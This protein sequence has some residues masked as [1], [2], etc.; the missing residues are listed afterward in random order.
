M[1][2][3]KGEKMV[4]RLEGCILGA[5][6]RLNNGLLAAQSNLYSW[7]EVDDQ[8]AA[9]LVIVD[10]EHGT[11]SAHS[12][13]HVV[14]GDGFQCDSEEE[15]TKHLF[16]ELE[17]M[18]MAVKD[19]G[20]LGEVKEV[21][22]VPPEYRERSASKGGEEEM[23]LEFG[24][25]EAKYERN[26][27]YPRNEGS[28]PAACA[29]FNQRFRASE[30][31]WVSWPRIGS[32]TGA[33]IEV[34]TRAQGLAGPTLG[35]QHTCAL[36]SGA[37]REASKG[38]LSRRVEPSDVLAAIEQAME[39]KAL[40][41]SLD[42]VLAIDLVDL[43]LTTLLWNLDTVGAVRERARKSRWGAVVLCGGAIPGYSESWVIHPV[44]DE[45]CEP[46]PCEGFP[47][48]KKIID[49]SSKAH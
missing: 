21:K 46:L 7:H 26:R 30:L 13:L 33:D 49:A 31:P 24:A 27:N 48:F 23:R 19:G 43:P 32:E 10:R 42:L 47:M 17:Q 18:M 6:E 44:A 1:Q 38:E 9:S 15:L 34:V 14:F 22:V 28:V 36:L 8:D 5:V 29:E 4:S 20:A 25:G 2:Y 41:G 12:V 11:S 35:V 37:G 16:S 40:N 39:K 45:E 3:E